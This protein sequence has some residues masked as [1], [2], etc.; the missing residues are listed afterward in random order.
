MRLGSPV[1]GSWN[2]WYSICAARSRSLMS[3]ATNTMPAGAPKS[4]RII[5]TETSTSTR[6]LSRRRQIIGRSRTMPPRIRV[7]EAL[8]TL[9]GV[10]MTSSRRRPQ[11]LAAPVAEQHAGGGVGDANALLEVAHQHRA[12]QRLEDLVGGEAGGDVDE[13]MA[14]HRPRDQHHARRHRH[15][16]Q[17]RDVP[18]EGRQEVDHAQR[19]DAEGGAE[20]GSALAV[21]ALVGGAQLARE[22]AEDGEQ[23][24]E[25][26]DDDRHR[27]RCQQGVMPPRVEVDAE[28]DPRRRLRNGGEDE[29][30]GPQEGDGALLLAVAAD[31]A[32]GE[33]IGRG[34]DE[35]HAEV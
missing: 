4:S 26:D 24:A 2:A 1:S 20:G 32:G 30:G 29:A 7:S 5:D 8:P 21:R 12:L 15:H 11:Q 19:A 34:G 16:A 28:D 13:A 33:V 18:A 3:P 27:R 17:R 22:E 9:R 31:E 35:R 10:S 23:H 25:I 6:L 14:V